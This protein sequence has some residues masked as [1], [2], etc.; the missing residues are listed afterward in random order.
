MDPKPRV[1][2]LEG[3]KFVNSN[4]FFFNDADFIIWINFLDLIFSY[5]SF[6]V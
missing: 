6:C 1:G 4:S 3:D 2:P 5:D